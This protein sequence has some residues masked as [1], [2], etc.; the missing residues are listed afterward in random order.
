MSKR[1]FLYL[2]T[3]L[4]LLG[5]TFGCKQILGEKEEEETLLQSLLLAA[6]LLQPV[7]DYYA[8]LY[9]L[10]P[11]LAATP[12]NATNS[13]LIGEATAANVDASKWKLIL[14]HGWHLDDRSLP[15]YPSPL[16]LK[17][18]IL[19]QNWSEFM[20]TSE[21]DEIY[22]TLDGGNKW[23]I[24]A[25]DYLTSESVADNGARFRA[26]MDALFGAET[27]T[28]VIY[29]HSMGGIVS[30]FAV[31]EGSAAPAYL[32]QVISTGTPYHGSP[33]ASPQF[34]ADRGPL[35][36][37][38]GFLTDTTGGRDLGWDNYDGSLP[39]ASNPT[40]DI[41]NNQ[42]TRDSLFFAFYGA[43]LNTDLPT[44]VP[45]D[46]GKAL[47]TALACSTLGATFSP[48]DC[49]VPQNSAEL[50][51]H[52]A[53]NGSAGLGKYDHLDIKMGAPSIRSAFYTQLDSLFP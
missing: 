6:G 15:V 11:Y 17:D 2:I 53:I 16:Q 40:L 20:K 43:I 37:I 50:G 3:L 1:F 45:G 26:K 35:G 49:I 10:N 52:P 47:V 32:K 30:R 41:V 23:D 19:A 31:Y 8:R 44:D 24:F 21:Y 28:V 5:S 12:E 27:G 51:D 18:R 13:D 33:W 25:F 14:V 36:A 46:S 38:A 42:D 48:S 9:Y 7:G 22:T 39:G 29:A 34:Q 4:L